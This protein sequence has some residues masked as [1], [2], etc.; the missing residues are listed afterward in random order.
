MTI[1]RWIEES[2]ANADV[3]FLFTTASS[4]PPRSST[5]WLNLLK[6]I[7]NLFC[8]PEDKP[9]PQ[10]QHQQQPWQQQP[11]PQYPPHQHQQPYHPQPSYPQHQQQHGQK[12]SSPHH[13]EKH[14]DLNQINQSNEF[15]VGLRARA[16]EEG[17]AMAKAFEQSKQAYGQGDGAAAKTLSNRGKEHQRN[18][19]SLNRQAADWIFIENNKDSK[20]GEIDLHGLYVKEAIARTDQAIQEAKQRGDSELHLIVGKGLHSKGGSAKIKPAVEELM[21]RHRLQA[22]LDPHNAGVLVVQINSGGSRGVGADEITR[23]LERKD[24]GCTVM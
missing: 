14:E 13:P 12:P 6:T 21:Q 15:Y 4:Y 16:N 17:D 10:Q 3:E 11:Q 9:P 18:M 23:R 2:D 8:G 1:N 5:M 22:E 19:E 24:E 7:F 20:P